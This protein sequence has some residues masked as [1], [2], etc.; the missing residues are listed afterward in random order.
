MSEAS[1]PHEP[2]FLIEAAGNTLTNRLEFY[3]TPMK[4]KVVNVGEF[5]RSG[6]FQLLKTNISS[7]KRTALDELASEKP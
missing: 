2:V 4:T 5:P 6:Q 1:T 7:E 3:E